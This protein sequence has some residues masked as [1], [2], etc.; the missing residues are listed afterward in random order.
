MRM[1]RK[2]ILVHLGLEHELYEIPEKW[3]GYKDLPVFKKVME[4]N[5]GCIGA[6]NT[7]DL[8]KGYILQKI[9]HVIWKLNHG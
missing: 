4:C 8:K 6:N 1:R 5:N 7:N 2:R 3:D 9:L